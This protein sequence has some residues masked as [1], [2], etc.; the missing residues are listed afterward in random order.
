MENMRVAVEVRPRIRSCH[1]F[2]N[3]INDPKSVKIIEES[4]LI[5]YGHNEELRIYVK[6]F[7]LTTDS[8][9]SLQKTNN[10]LYFQT[11]TNPEI[12]NGSFRC[13]LLLNNKISGEDASTDFYESFKPDIEA[14]VPV[15]L[16]CRCCL[17]PVLQEEVL[18]DRILPLPDSDG[19]DFFCHPVPE[20]C[21]SFIDLNPRLRDCLYNN[22]YFKI[23]PNHIKK[24]N[25]GTIYCKKCGSWLGIRRESS[26]TLWNSG[27]KYNTDE[28]SEA[29]NQA[30]EDFVLL[31]KALAK[32]EA[33]ITCKLILN[34]MFDDE[35]NHYLLLWI[36]DKSLPLFINDV[37]I[38]G[39]LQL[40][41]T[42]VVKV[43]YAY[44]KE[45]TDIIKQWKEDVRVIEVE[46][47]KQMLVEGISLLEEMSNIIP[48]DFRKTNQFNVSY[49]K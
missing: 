48:Q 38:D 41:E 30:A 9:I 42:R 18:F 22:F 26:V 19:S 32:K 46:I 39:K 36:M 3:F 2:I 23:N 25:N 43:L 40:S 16:Y 20:S 8:V 10:S 49:I 27:I 15:Q 14:G 5:K 34:S 44:E 28:E 29:N 6:D 37:F 7:N 13:E 17:T 24:E 11:R 21:A 33:G 31:V 45:E 47:S 12:S 35:N 4:I 1:F